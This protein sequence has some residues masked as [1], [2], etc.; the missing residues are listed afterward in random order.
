MLSKRAVR[1]RGV[2]MAMKMP[3]V[4]ES[5]SKASWAKDGA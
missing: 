1:Q 2:M 3:I 4:N 5:K